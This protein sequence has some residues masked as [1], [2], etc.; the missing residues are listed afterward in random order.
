L[1]EGAVEPIFGKFNQDEEQKLYCPFAE[2][3][4]WP[5]PCNQLIVHGK[6]A[7]SH[8]KIWFAALFSALSILATVSSESA[9][10]GEVD[11][12]GIDR[13]V[14]IQRLFRRAK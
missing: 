3:G 1:N 4:R 13:V 10:A 14:L 2:M 9:I 12:T 5:R 8:A 6:R 11:I 7:M